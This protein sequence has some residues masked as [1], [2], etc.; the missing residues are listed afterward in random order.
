[1]ARSKSQ[2][3]DFLLAERSRSTKDEGRRTV[4]FC[5]IHIRW[6]WIGPSSIFHTLQDT[7]QVATIYEAVSIHAGKHFIPFLYRWR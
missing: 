7:L 5:S 2:W 3:N 1:M 4:D 6:L